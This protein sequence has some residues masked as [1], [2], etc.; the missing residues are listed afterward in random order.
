MLQ[1]CLGIVV[2]IEILDKNY[3]FYLNYFYQKILIEFDDD[4]I[5]GKS[6]KSDGIGCKFGNVEIL[7][8]KNADCNLIIDDIDATDAPIWRIKTGIKGEHCLA[9]LPKIQEIKF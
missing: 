1:Y 2:E 3:K 9:Y 4:I 8:S 7:S 5:K 6:S